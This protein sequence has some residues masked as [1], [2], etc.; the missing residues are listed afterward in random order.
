MHC[1]FH[2][3]GSGEYSLDYDLKK[4]LLYLVPFNDV[5]GWGGVICCLAL[6]PLLQSWM[7]IQI[8]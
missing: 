2:E 4:N 6:V 3:Y 8:T 1:C 5:S 7:S